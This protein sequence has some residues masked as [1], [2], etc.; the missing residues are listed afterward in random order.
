MNLKDK[1]KESNDYRE[2]LK[3]G[4]QKKWQQENNPKV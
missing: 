2:P 3:K 4:W 1:G